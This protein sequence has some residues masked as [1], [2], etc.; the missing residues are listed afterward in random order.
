[1]TASIV[2]SP[3]E[4]EAPSPMCTTSRPAMEARMTTACSS[5]LTMC[6]RFSEVN[7]T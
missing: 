3:L 6:R 4:L 7:A 1:M 5:R 2:A